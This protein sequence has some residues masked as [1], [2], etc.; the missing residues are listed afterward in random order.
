MASDN[1]EAELAEQFCRDTGFVAPGIDVPPGGNG[2]KN[3]PKRRASRWK[4][5][6]SQKCALW[7]YLNHGPKFKPGEPPMPQGLEP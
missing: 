1:M 2:W 7:E 4:W 3:D 6:L 5:W